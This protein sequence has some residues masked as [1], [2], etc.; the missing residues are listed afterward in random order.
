MRSMVYVTV[1]CP[2]VRL[3]VCLIDRQQQQRPVGLLLRALRA[4]SCGRAG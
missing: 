4:D 1:G 3:F 2:S